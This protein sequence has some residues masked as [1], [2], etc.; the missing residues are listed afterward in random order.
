MPPAPSAPASSRMRTDA[1]RNA[2]RIVRAAEQVFIESGTEVTLEEIALRAGV[3]AATLYRHFGS[4]AELAR[5]AVEHAFAEQVEPALQQAL[6][7]SQDALTTLVTALEAVMTMI[8][9]HR[10][11]L[12]AA[13]QP[14]QFP[15]GLVGHYYSRLEILLA[16]A[17]QQGT[18]RADLD[19]ED[20]PRL[21]LMVLN[22]MWL[23]DAPDNWRRYLMLLLDA[24]QPSA[25]RPLPPITPVTTPLPPL[26][27]PDGDDLRCGANMQ[28]P[29]SCQRG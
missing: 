3:G 27:P 29:G 25:A 6:D 14:G 1:R 28:Q 11:A 13:M 18:V 4:K 21:T 19:A 26:P 10:N 9:Q 5:A 7:D 8:A 20:L 2:E 17:Q 15:T 16:R 24:L 12:A 22:T 23:N